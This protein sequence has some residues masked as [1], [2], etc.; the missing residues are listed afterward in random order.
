MPGLALR[1]R[2]PLALPVDVIQ[3]QRGDLAAAQ[4]VGHQQQQDRLVAL[5]ARGAPIDAGEHLSD[6]LPRDRPRDA[7]QPVDLRPLHHAAQIARDRPPR[8]ARSARTRAAPHSQSR[9][10]V[11][12]NPA[13]A[14]SATNALRI[15]GESSDSRAT[16]IRAKIRLEARKVMPIATDRRRPQTTLT[17][18]Y[19]K[20]PGS[21]SANGTRTTPTAATDKAGN[22]QPQHLLD[23]AADLLDDRSPA[24]HDDDVR[25]SDPLGHER[26]DMNRQIPDDPGATRTRELPEGDQQRHP[27]QHRPRRV[28]VLSQPARHTARSPAPIHDART[29]STVCGLTKY[30]SNMRTTSSPLMGGGSTL[31]PRHASVM[32]PA[33]GDTPTPNPVIAGTQ[34]IAAPTRPHNRVGHRRRNMWRAT[35]SV[36]A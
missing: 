28:A 1:H 21:A 7:R 34:V 30:A 20:N 3:R 11:F 4:P 27:P 8:G 35:Y 19:S 25:R 5:A 13:P 12:A 32:W 14:R 6:L 23:R 16:P 31:R 10:V 9:N 2:E 18:R 29:R 15:A 24:R 17:T 22:H 26:I 36:N 33:A